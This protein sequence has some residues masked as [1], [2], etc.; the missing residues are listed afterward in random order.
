M[1]N[2]VSEEV[3]EFESF[4]NLTRAAVRVPRDLDENLQILYRKA[5]SR[6]PVRAEIWYLKSACQPAR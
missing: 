5:H 6:L 4:C 1:K 2:A 3:G